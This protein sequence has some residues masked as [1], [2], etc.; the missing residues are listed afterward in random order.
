[1]AIFPTLFLGNLGQENVF[2]DVLEQ[3]KIFLGNKNNKLRKSKNWHI[4]Q[5]G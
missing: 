1:M 2:Y 5:R 4:F 3:K